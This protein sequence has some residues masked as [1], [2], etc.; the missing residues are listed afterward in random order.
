M[1]AAHRRCFFNFRFGGGF[2][3]I[4]QVAADGIG[5]E[6]GVLQHDGY[7]LTQ[8]VPCN[9]FHVLVV[10][11]DSA[12]VNIVVTHQQVDYS[13]FAAAGGTYQRHL[14]AC[15]NGKVEIFQYRF[16]FIVTEL[17]VFKPYCHVLVVFPDQAVQIFAGLV[18]YLE[19]TFRAGD[20]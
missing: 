5:E 12:F 1:A 9:F 18:Q 13:G 19:H 11:P 7:V 10:D 16:I 14:F 6:D 20:G 8:A 2:I 15:G 3:C 17:Y 4:L